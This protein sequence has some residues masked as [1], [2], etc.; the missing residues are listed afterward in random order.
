MG[1]YKMLRLYMQNKWIYSLPLLSS[2]FFSPDIMVTALV[3]A[4]CC[5]DTI[6]SFLR[7]FLYEGE[8]HPLERGTHK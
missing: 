2:F 1:K 5:F 7:H 8:I 4:I 3:S 6:F